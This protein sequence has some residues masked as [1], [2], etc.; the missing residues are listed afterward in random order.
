M[1]NEET[2][3]INDEDT[4]I[5]SVHNGANAEQ[6]EVNAKYLK[7]Y[8][9][10]VTQYLQHLNGANNLNGRLQPSFFPPNGFWTAEEKD[11]FFHALSVHSRFRPDL[12]AAEIPGK[13]MVDVCVYI[14]MLFEASSKD[15]RRLSQNAF[16]PALE[17]SEE[18]IAFEENQATAMVFNEATSAQELREE[19]RSMILQDE[20]EAMRKQKQK[21]IE[22]GRDREEEKRRRAAYKKFQADR[23]SHWWQE[24][25]MARL[26]SVRLRVIDNILQEAEEPRETSLDAIDVGDQGYHTNDSRTAISNA[27]IDPVLLSMSDPQSEGIGL[28]E[29]AEIDGPVAAA[30]QGLEECDLSKL[31]PRSRRRYKKRLHMRRKR[32]VA[33]GNAVSQSMT[34][35]KPGRKSNWKKIHSPPQ[36]DELPSGTPVPFG[37]PQ[38]GVEPTLLALDPDDMDEKDEYFDLHAGKEEFEVDLDDTLSHDQ[39]MDDSRIYAE[40]S[41]NAN[42]HQL[43][44]SGATA[45]YKLKKDLLTHGNDAARLGTLGLGLF[46]LSNIEKLMK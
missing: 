31:S 18:W 30:S 24:D 21:S 27:A 45:F 20:K 44:A 2:T 28:Q 42:V 7:H 9:N 8:R 13:T 15:H 35:L 3:E 17:V 37:E 25:F 46:H 5:S 43:H 36:V 34:K 39:E 4:D 12:I 14:S 40:F 6:V 11:L 26:D 19:A 33:R 38:P 10:S 23:E 32:A 16:L 29:T 1:D 22:A 41:N